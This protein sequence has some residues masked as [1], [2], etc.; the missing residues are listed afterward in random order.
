MQ[1]KTTSAIF[2]LLVQGSTRNPAQKKIMRKDLIIDLPAI[3][4]HNHTLLEIIP[5]KG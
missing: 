5:K 3:N 4:N 2:N 1:D